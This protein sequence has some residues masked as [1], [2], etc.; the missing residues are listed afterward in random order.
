MF[1]VI[2][3]VIKDIEYVNRSHKIQNSE[4]ARVRGNR[5]AGCYCLVFGWIVRNIMCKNA[6]HE[7]KVELSDSVLH[8]IKSVYHFIAD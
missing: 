5:F 8:S 1:L 7:G 4:E 3:I 6:Y 2:K